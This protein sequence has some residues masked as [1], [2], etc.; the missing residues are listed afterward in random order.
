MSGFDNRNY[1]SFGSPIQDQ[2]IS[3]GNFTSPSIHGLESLG[4][5]DKVVIEQEW[6]TPK[7]TTYLWLSANN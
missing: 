1:N 3:S 6:E 5:V 7:G 2:P 4:S